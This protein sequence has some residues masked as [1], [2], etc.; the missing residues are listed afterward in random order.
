M[1]E[2][3]R[4]ASQLGDGKSEA[5]VMHAKMNR[6][7]HATYMLS[8]LGDGCT[9]LFSFALSLYISAMLDQL[10]IVDPEREFWIGLVATGYG[11]VYPFSAVLLGKLSDRVGRRNSLLIAIAGFIFVNVFVLVFATQ[12]LH[13]LIALMGVGLCFGFVFPVLEALMSELSEPFGQKI[14]GRTL[15][16]FMVAWS[17]GLTLG[18]LIGGIFATF[19]NFLVAFGYLIA[20]ASLFAAIALVFIPGSKTIKNYTNYFKGSAKQ[21][22]QVDFFFTNMPKARFRF[23]Q[24]SILLLPLVFAFCNQILY[25]I[26]PA[27]GEK[28]VSGGIIL[29][30]ANPA[31]VVGIL[32]FTLGVG[33]TITFWHSGHMN[34]NNFEKYI[35]LSPA[36]MAAS[37]FIIFVARTAEF[38]LPAFAIYG[39]SSGY[40]YAIGFILLMEITRTGKGLKA[41]L[42]EGA[43][44]IGTLASTLI[45]AFIGQADPSYPYLLS[46]LFALA[47]AVILAVAYVHQHQALRK[48]P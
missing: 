2:A 14:H 5:L 38:L 37:G 22:E 33:R 6:A 12:P 28:H 7:I 36:V 1:A 42:Y 48:I 44:G 10:G 18:P 3:A 35:I 13:L 45:S 20:H 39:L 26:Y 41:G 17:L 11:F 34:Q 40:Q 29:D 25:V 47:I 8:F 19:L 21:E 30:N 4:G 43:I 15:G 27:F 16:I 23:Y 46:M 24:I 32:I 31:L 9:G